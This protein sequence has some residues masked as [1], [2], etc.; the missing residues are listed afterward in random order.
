MTKSFKVGKNWENL[1]KKIEEESKKR[2]TTNRQILSD[3]DALRCEDNKGLSGYNKELGCK[4]AKNNDNIIS[5]NHYASDKGFE[6]FDVQEAFIH[7]L[8]GMAASY[9]CNV[10]K[11]ILRFQRKNGVED[12]KKAKYYLEKLIE[13]EEKE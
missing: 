6:V 5:P 3:I 8:K 9:W 12:L 2:V 13:E 10:V 4:E 1:M 11:Y 7:E